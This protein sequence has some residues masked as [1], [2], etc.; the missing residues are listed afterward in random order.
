VNALRRTYQV[1]VGKQN[2][3]ERRDDT[4]RL[5]SDVDPAPPTTITTKLAMFAVTFL[6]ALVGTAVLQA[7]R[8]SRR[9]LRAC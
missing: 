8:R 2:S 7:F 9:R 3:D 6:T 1:L 4:G 5:S